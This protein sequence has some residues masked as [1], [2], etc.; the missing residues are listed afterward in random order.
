LYPKSRLDA[1][2]DG[3]FAVAMTIL[4]LDL[5]IPEEFQ[6]QDNAALAQALLALLSKF[7]P[8]VLSFVVLGI[9]WLSLLRA[10]STDEMLGFAYAKW[11]LLYLLSVTCIPFS[12]LLIGRF[13]HVPLAN[14][15]YA[16]NMLLIAAIGYRLMMLLPHPRIDHHWRARKIALIVLMISCALAIA[17]S[18]P[19]PGHA[20]LAFLLNLGV[21]VILRMTGRKP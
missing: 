1:L 2:T 4:V 21:P 7:F 3:V 5:K 6:T 12:T 10:T 15:V 18:L 16:A 17:L 19:Y 13:N 9:S 11:W 20:M 8:Y 14:V